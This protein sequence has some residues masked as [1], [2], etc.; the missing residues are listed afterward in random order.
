MSTVNVVTFAWNGIHGI[1]VPCGRRRAI[2]FARWFG[3]TGL[4][5]SVGRQIDLDRGLYL[6]CIAKGRWELA[7]P[8]DAVV[9]AAHIL[10]SQEAA[11]RRKV[12]P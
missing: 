6:R 4:L 2:R 7:G 9:L 3:G 12:S 11:E 5:P 8:D 10:R 1:Y